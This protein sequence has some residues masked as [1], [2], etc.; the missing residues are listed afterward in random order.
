MLASLAWSFVPRRCGYVIDCPRNYSLADVNASAA[1]WREDD[2]PLSETL[3]RLEAQAE[4]ACHA[5][6]AN[7]GTSSCQ[8]K[9]DTSCPYLKHGGW[10]LED[11]GA[12]A[13]ELPNGQTYLLPRHHAMADGLVVAFLSALLSGSI[14]G[15]CRSGRTPLAVADFGAGV[16]QYG[17]S[18]LSLQPDVRWK[19]YDGAGNVRTFTGGFVSFIDLTVPVALPRADWVVSLEVGEHVHYTNEYMLIRNLHAHNCRG[20]IISWARLGQWGF[21]H[22]NNHSPSYVAKTFAELGYR[23]SPLL[24]NAIRKGD[25]IQVP[26]DHN[27]TKERYFWFRRT[28]VAVFERLSPLESPGCTPCT[29]RSSRAA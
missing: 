1:S 14:A 6:K 28:S 27:A 11:K 17:H 18:L 21:G 15:R 16:G 10:C 12:S 4:Q 25:G 3:G 24:S 26:R 5:R 9:G 7:A 20:V 8:Q 23:Y 29:M 2:P 22:I 13:V 19:G